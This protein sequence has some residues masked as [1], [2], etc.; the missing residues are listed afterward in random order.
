MRGVKTGA[1][2]ALLALTLAGCGAMDYT[3][4]LFIS[5]VSLEV[6]GTQFTST[7]EQVT[8]GC[9]AQAIPKDLCARY[10][11]FGL[12]FKRVYPV[13]VGLWQAAE[14]AGD[15]TAKRKAEDV[16]QALARDLTRLAV[17]ALGSL[18]PE[19]K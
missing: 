2:V 15:T 9:E 14:R 18:S 10:R 6:L 7:T 17:E 19:E 4:S 8:K 16:T 1:I 3:K 11:A 12:R 13:T 5:G